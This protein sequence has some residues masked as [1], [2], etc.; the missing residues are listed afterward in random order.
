MFEKIKDNKAFLGEYTIS[1]T[2]QGT[3]VMIISQLG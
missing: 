2:I 3:D 1:A